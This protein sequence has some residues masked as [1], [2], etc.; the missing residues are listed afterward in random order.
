MTMVSLWG[1]ETLWWRCIPLRSSWAPELV[2][3]WKPEWGLRIWELWLEVMVN[4]QKMCF[5]NEER[6]WGPESCV[7]H[8]GWRSQ[9]RDDQRPRKK[10]KKHHAEGLGWEGFLVP[11]ASRAVWCREEHRNRRESE[12]NRGCL[13]N[14]MENRLLGIEV[15]L[16]YTHR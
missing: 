6:E 10:V 15:C 11:A 3:R 2:C 5:L 16:F 4:S 8:L 12:E 7:G 13:R 9:F 14:G 1:M